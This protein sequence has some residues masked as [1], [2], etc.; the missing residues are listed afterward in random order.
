MK[1]IKKLPV[2][3]AALV[4]FM[5]LITP[6]YAQ[7]PWMIGTEP[8]R[9]DTVWGTGA[10]ETPTHINP[11]SNNPDPFSQLMFETLFGQNTE[12]QVYVP[13]I[14]TDFTWV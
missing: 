12:K 2:A 13:C 1:S 8:P 7:L 3:I 10:Y 5:M 11:W 4:I 6:S 14:G 9:D